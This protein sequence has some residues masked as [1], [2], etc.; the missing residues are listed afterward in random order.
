MK[1]KITHGTEFTSEIKS[2]IAK[3]EH[4]DYFKE[5]IRQFEYYQNVFEKIFTEPNQAKKTNNMAYSFLVQYKGMGGGGKKTLAIREFDILDNQTLEDL[6]KCIVLSM[7]WVYDHMHGYELIGKKRLS[8][9]LHTASSLAIFAEGWEDDPHP[10]YKTNEIHI[11]GI[12]YDVQPKFEFTFDYGDGH[13]FL[14]VSTG[15]SK[16]DPRDDLSDFPR[17]ISS[18]GKAPEQ[19]PPL[20]A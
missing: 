9:P 18:S 7:G 20:A 5:L 6:A 2:L 15:C 12:D 1:P 10:T 17:L 3:G 4:V 19:Y 8:D 11:S 14:V 13:T 16:I